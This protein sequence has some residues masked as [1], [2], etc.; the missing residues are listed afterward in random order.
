MMVVFVALHALCPTDLLRIPNLHQKC[1]FAR[2]SLPWT[3]SVSVLLCQFSVAFSPF[4]LSVCWSPAYITQSNLS[5]RAVSLLI[6]LILLNLLQK[7]QFVMVLGYKLKVLVRE[8]IVFRAISFGL[9]R[10]WNIAKRF[11][12]LLLSIDLDAKWLGDEKN[13]LRI[14]ALMAFFE[15]AAVSSK[16]R[17]NLSAHI[18][19]RTINFVILNQ[20]KHS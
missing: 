8:F 19:R 11:Q 20:L 4:L 6:E 12:C 3:A 9:H 18:W 2:S 5:R 15:A 13:L 17:M 16:S 1:S 7:I 14:V 10:Q